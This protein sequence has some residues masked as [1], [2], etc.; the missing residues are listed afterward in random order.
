MEYPEYQQDIDVADTDKALAESLEQRTQ[1]EDN[2]GNTTKYLEIPDFP[3]KEIIVP[4]EKVWGMFD[5]F[6]RQD[7][8][9]NQEHMNPSYVFSKT[10]R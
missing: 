5:D 6:Y 3:I 4:A 7:C 8:F 10:T 2:Y 1:K 9:T